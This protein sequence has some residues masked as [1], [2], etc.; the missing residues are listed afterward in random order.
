MR[1]PEIPGRALALCPPALAMKLAC[2]KLFRIELETP[3]VDLVDGF[4]Y[5]HP[6]TPWTLVQEEPGDPF[7]LQGYFETEESGRSAFATLRDTPGLGELPEPEVVELEDRDWKEAYKFHLKPWR[8]GPLLWLPVWDAEDPQHADPETHRVLLDSGMAFGTGSHETT[9]LCAEA[10]VA[11]FE[12]QGDVSE[13]SVVDAGCGSGVLALSAAVLGYGTVRG[14]DN[15][16]E[17]VRISQENVTL[18]E[19]EG[20][21]SFSVDDLST[22][23]TSKCAD[24]LLANIETPILREFRREL[25]AA[26]RPAGVLVMS[27]ILSRDADSLARDFEKSA[28]ECW[29]EGLVGGVDISELG[30]WG[31]LVLVRG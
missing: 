7:L 12:G 20:A 10:L 27:G 21:L 6:E 17:A 19:L 4:C 13:L 28:R 16:P 3:V 11:A 29:P 23:L 8:C 1:D 9:Q 14:F 30:E 24:V 22:G 15:D 2:M 25:L 18:N 5:E 26:V 31:R